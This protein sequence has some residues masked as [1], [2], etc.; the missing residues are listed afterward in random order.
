MAGRSNLTDI[1]VKAAQSTSVVVDYNRSAA[2]TSP[3]GQV[4]AGPTLWPP[5]H[6]SSTAEEGVFR[7][8]ITQRV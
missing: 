4:I 5:T 7:R 6:A 2:G 3:V 8:H 1:L